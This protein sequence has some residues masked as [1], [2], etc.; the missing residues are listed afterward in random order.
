[1]Y[2]NKPES[3]VYMIEN[4]SVGDGEIVSASDHPMHAIDTFLMSLGKVS[5]TTKE[6][7][8][9]EPAVH[10]FLLGGGRKIG[11]RF[12]FFSNIFMVTGF[13]P[14]PLVLVRLYKTNPNFID[15]FL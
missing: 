12:T 1:M 10:F 8:K 11:V 2:Q 5:K 4:Y 3:L 15:F 9:S 13:K 6:E 7:E 14:F